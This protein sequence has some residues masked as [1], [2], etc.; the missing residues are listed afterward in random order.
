MQD[1]TPE[2]AISESYTKQVRSEMGLMERQLLVLC[3]RQRAG[4]AAFI[5]GGLVEMLGQSPSKRAVC[6]QP[7]FPDLLGLGVGVLI[8]GPWEVRDRQG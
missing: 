7:V 2:L 8:C 4:V 3:S 6:T 5:A 1:V